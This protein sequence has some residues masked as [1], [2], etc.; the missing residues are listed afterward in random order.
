MSTSALLSNPH[1]PTDERSSASF[2]VRCNAVEPSIVASAGLPSN[3]TSTNEAA[4]PLADITAMTFGHFSVLVGPEVPNS[5]SRLAGFEA[6]HA[7][8]SD[9]VDANGSRLAVFV[10]V[11]ADGVPTKTHLAACE[12]YI[13]QTEQSFDADTQRRFAHTTSMALQKR[14]RAWQRRVKDL[15]ARNTELDRMASYAA[16]EF[17]TPL[18]SIMFDAEYMVAKLGRELESS[19][20]SVEGG[21]RADRV[22][23]V[24]L[25]AQRIYDQSAELSS[26]LDDLLVVARS[27]DGPLKIGMIDLEKLVSKILERHRH[28]IA[29]VGAAVEVGSMSA[30]WSNEQY[31]AIVVSNLISNAI[32]FRSENRDLQIGVSSETQDGCVLLSVADNGIGISEEDHD[33]IFSPFHRLDESIQGLGLGLS[34]SAKLLARLGAEFVVSSEPGC[35]SQ[36][37]IRL[38]QV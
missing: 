12:V 13:A 1:P 36:F 37:T 18:R 29:D 38:P 27:S 34:L 4:Q 31:L 9:L 20:P 22:V 10:S 17:K 3:P 35:G 14:E 8:V 33:Q 16:H 28:S 26:Q 7:V 19:S 24:S 6:Q 2:V 11:G 21:I 5:F 25:T 15:T 30:V 32:R 23:E